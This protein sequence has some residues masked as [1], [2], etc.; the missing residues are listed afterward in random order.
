MR[1]TQRSVVARLL[2]KSLGGG[3]S[4]Y[5]LRTAARI[6][7]F[8]RNA[9]IDGKMFTAERNVI[10]PCIPAVLLQSTPF[11]EFQQLFNKLRRLPSDM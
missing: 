4:E 8:P 11:V 7:A 2:R 10:S 9:V 3:G 1:P 5:S 6:R